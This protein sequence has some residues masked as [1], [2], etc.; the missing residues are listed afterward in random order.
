MIKHGATKLHLVLGNSLKF[1]SDPNPGVSEALCFRNDVGALS[2]IR[3]RVVQKSEIW[4]GW[5]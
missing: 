4:M 1:I 2:Q 3:A 5:E